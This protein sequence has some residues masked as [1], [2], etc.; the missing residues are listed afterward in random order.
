MVH[1]E[2]FVAAMKTNDNSILNTPI[3]SGSVATINVQMGNIAYKTGRKVYWDIDK[4]MFKDDQAT[5]DL[6]KAHYHN[7]WSL[8]KI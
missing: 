4:G 2:N 1:C 6:I 3:D 7:G 8:P 5:N